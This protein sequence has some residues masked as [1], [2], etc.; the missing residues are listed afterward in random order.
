MV[1]ADEHDASTVGVD[2][3]G[4]DDGDDGHHLHHRNSQGRV[5]DL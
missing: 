5:S 2:V 4:R 3:D 1:T